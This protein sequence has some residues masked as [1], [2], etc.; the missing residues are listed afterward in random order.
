MLVASTGPVVDTFFLSVFA[1][2]LCETGA[3]V[4][5]VT[6]RAVCALVTVT[7]RV[8][9]ALIVVHALVSIST[10]VEK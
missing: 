3:A 5:R 7:T 1:K 6:A 8:V 10:V 2:I 4:A 9:R